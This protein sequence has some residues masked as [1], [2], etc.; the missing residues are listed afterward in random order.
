ME[1]RIDKLTVYSRGLAPSEIQAIYN[2]GSEGK[3]K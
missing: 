3:S 1:G 2:A